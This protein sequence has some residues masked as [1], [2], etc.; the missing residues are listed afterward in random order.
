MKKPN[1]YECKWRASLPGSA[2]SQCNHPKNSKVAEEP[3]LK[4]LAILGSVGRGPSIQ[5]ETGL[6][7][8]GNPH[9]IANGWFG[10][11]FDFDPTWLE[12]CDGFDRL[13]T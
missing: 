4:L 12:K 10:W 11:P 13:S 2:H 3:L 1:C 5:A 8:E 6:H 9:G 7:I